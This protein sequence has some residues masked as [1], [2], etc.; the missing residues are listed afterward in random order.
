MNN[1]PVMTV[2]DNGDLHIHIPMIIRRMRGRKTVIIPATLSDDDQPQAPAIQSQEA[3]VQ[4]LA[5]AYSWAEMIESGEVESIAEL[6]RKLDMDGSYITRILRLRT[7]APDII[8]A[9][10]NG[11]EP[12]GLSLTNLTKAF[13]GEW[14]E[15]RQF[16]GF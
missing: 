3:L 16:F 6:A 15:Q 4:A 7:L 11:E 2:L 5:R 10:L 13:P 9:I 14:Q 12:D 1:Q 8:E